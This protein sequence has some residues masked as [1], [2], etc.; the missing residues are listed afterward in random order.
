MILTCCEQWRGAKKNSGVDYE[1]YVV[2]PADKSILMARCSVFAAMLKNNMIESKQQA[3][4]I[5]DSNPA[6]IETLVS[7]LHRGI[8]HSLRGIPREMEDAAD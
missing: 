1:S 8:G 2:I 7:L 6:A 5:E 4:E 3:V